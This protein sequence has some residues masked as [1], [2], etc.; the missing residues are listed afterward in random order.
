MREARDPRISGMGS[1]RW[2]LA[3]IALGVIAAVVAV[4]M[5]SGDGI[6][7]STDSIPNSSGNSEGGAAAI[8]R[9]ASALAAEVQARQELS[10]QIAELKMEVS[11][12]RLAPDGAA[13]TSLVQNEWPNDDAGGEARSDLDASTGA[14]GFDDER[15]LAQRVH[16]SDVARLHDLWVNHELERESIADRALREGWFMQK[17]HSAELAQL[18]RELR[19]DLQDADY[20]RYLYA[21]GE[22]NRLRAGEVLEGSTARAAGLRRGDTI[23]RYNDVRVFKPGELLLASSG[24][25]PGDMVPVDIDRDGYRKRIYVELGPLGVK[26]EHDSGPPLDE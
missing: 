24:G 7:Q 26:I 18:D 6:V 16:P 15:L 21:L 14:F 11:R 19:E 9:L 12:L 23:L 17:R 13:A 5:G 10:D 1:S 22:P 4:R 3:G 2:L 20:D 8:D 25:N